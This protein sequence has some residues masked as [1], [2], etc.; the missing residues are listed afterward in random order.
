[1]SVKSFTEL[2]LTITDVTCM[3]MTSKIHHSFVDSYTCSVLSYCK[4]IE[5]E[6]NSKNDNDLFYSCTQGLMT[7]GASAY[8]E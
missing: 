3:A 7:L 6:T 4:C 5:Q 1:M 8:C 2:L